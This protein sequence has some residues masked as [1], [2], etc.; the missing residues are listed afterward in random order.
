M[1]VWQL[2]VLLSFVVV[3]S[4]AIGRIV[5]ERHD[6]SPPGFVA[7]IGATLALALAY[8]GILHAGGFW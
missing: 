2:L 7:A 1:T 4:S 5:D 8:A 3:T 6:F